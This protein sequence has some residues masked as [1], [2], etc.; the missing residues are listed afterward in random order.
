V[1]RE[2]RLPAG[3]VAEFAPVP[4][5]PCHH[6]RIYIFYTVQPRVNGRPHARTHNK[7]VVRRDTP[8]RED[9]RMLQTF[10]IAYAIGVAATL[11]FATSPSE[12]NAI[13]LFT[14]LADAPT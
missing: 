10:N 3:G 6:R 13:F 2:T 8:P 7:N 14:V 1:A 9:S 11:R 4:R 5:L 12:K